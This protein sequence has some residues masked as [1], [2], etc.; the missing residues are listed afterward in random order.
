M[1]NNLNLAQTIENYIKDNNLFDVQKVEDNLFYSRQVRT[2]CV[3]DDRFDGEIDE[4]YIDFRNQK[5]PKKVY[6][7][8]FGEVIFV[9]NVDTGVAPVTVLFIYEYHH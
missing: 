9:C 1:N 6:Q 8:L 3:L 2:L 4:L 5:E 7:T